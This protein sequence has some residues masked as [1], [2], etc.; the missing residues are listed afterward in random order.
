MSIVAA[1][2]VVVRAGPA[3]MY[4]RKHFVFDLLGV[5]SWISKTL[6][7]SKHAQV[8]ASLLD[9]WPVKRSLV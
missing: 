2:I 3:S 8:A 5:C 7:L 6:S 9:E 4:K 1:P